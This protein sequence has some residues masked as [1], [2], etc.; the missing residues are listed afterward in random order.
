MEWCKG[1]DRG[2]PRPDLTFY[3]DIAPQDA[4]LRGEYGKERYESLEFQTKVHKVYQQLQESDWHLLNATAAIQATHSIIFELILEK[5]KK[6]PQMEIS[7]D[8]WLDKK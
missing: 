1:P 3:L 2:L 4:S 6:C 7:D 5:I 8:L